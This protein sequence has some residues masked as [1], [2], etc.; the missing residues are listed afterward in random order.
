MTQEHERHGDDA[1]PRAVVLA[2]F[3]S[4]VPRTAEWIA[5]ELDVDRE[6]AAATLSEL[7]DEGELAAAHLED[8]DDALTAYYLSPEAHPG[9]SIDPETAR[10]AAVQRTIAE[11]DV[12]GVSGMMQDWRRD[13]LEYAWE[14]LAEEGVASDREF[15]REVFPGHKAGYD[16]PEEWW[17][18]VRPRLARLPGVDGPGEDGSTW[19]YDAP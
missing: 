9:G 13:A 18:F 19:E 15:K 6:G 3:D 2:T 5:E 7:V 10:L 17:A 1:L 4:L 16:A 14:F 8:G 11:L 12:P